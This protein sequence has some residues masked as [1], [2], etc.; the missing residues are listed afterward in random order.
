[1]LNVVAEL[2]DDE[3]IKKLQVFNAQIEN[4]LR[5]A[6][7]LI[8]AFITANGERTSEKSWALFLDDREIANVAYDDVMHVTYDNRRHGT[9]YEVWRGRN[10]ATRH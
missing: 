10:E 1:M 3:Y 9:V 5:E 2:D 7:E 4:E 8:I 6:K